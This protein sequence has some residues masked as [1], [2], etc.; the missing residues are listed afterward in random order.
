MSER[1]ADPFLDLLGVQFDPDPVTVAQ[2]RAFC[3]ATGHPMP[4]LPAEKS[5]DQ[6]GITNV[7]FLDGEAYC[8]W[9]SERS[10]ILT[11]LPTEV[12][13]RALEQ[14]LNPARDMSAWPLPNLPDVGSR[15][16]TDTLTDPVIH[17]LLGYLYFWCANE[18]DRQASLTWW[19]ER[20]KAKPAPAE[21]VPA[22]SASSG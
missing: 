8:R 19:T 6:Q 18:E 15:R 16:E 10:G 21:A 7:S 11:V 4:D 3:A 12:E 17:D 2:Y 22:E 1:K 13:M 20:T 5:G 9:E 14:S